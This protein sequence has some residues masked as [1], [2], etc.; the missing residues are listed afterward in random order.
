MPEFLV[1][2]TFSLI[3]EMCIQIII[4]LDMSKQGGRSATAAFLMSQEIAKLTHLF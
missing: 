1:E 3:F 2:V 4:R